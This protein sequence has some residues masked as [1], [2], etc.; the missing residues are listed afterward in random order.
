MEEIERWID[1]TEQARALA[2]MNINP[3][4]ISLLESTLTTTEVPQTTYAQS[5][6]RRIG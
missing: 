4:F 2:F 1:E 5:L 3:S 6:S